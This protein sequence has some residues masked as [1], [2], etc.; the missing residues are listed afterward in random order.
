MIKYHIFTSKI[1]IIL[2]SS[3][4]RVIQKKKQIF[5]SHALFLPTAC[6]DQS[7]YKS[8]V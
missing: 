5:E 6:E 1:S 8:H 3:K 7:N 4:Y 2:K